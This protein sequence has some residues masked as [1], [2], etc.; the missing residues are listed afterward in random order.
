LT[1]SAPRWTFFGSFGSTRCARAVIANNSAAQP[2]PA[3]LKI[4]SDFTL[5][6]TAGSFVGLS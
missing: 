3:N 6:I 1:S 2:T 4:E 5:T